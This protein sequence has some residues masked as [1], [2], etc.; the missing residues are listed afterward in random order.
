MTLSYYFLDP[1][2][3]GNKPSLERSPGEKPKCKEPI[4]SLLGWI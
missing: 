1:K 2:N 4:R 3:N